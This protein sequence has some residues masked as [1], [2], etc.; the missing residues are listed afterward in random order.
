ML[1]APTEVV[2]PAE[3]AAVDARGNS[4]T[5]ALTAAHDAYCWGSNMFGQLGVSGNYGYWS[6]NASPAAV[7]GGYKFRKVS[8]GG[9]HTCGVGDDGSLWC[10]GSNG[11][12]EL[13]IAA[14][15]GGCGGYSQCQPSPSRIR[16]AADS[17]FTD[18]AAGYDHTC[19]LDA[20][21]AAYCWG[22]NA[23]GALGTGDTLSGSTPR[24]V[25]GDLV[26]V[27][28]TAGAQYTCGLTA[29]GDAYCWGTSY[30]GQLGSGTA[31]GSCGSAYYATP[32]E[33]APVMVS[34]GLRFSSLSA[35]TSMTCGM[36][37]DGAWC[38]GSYWGPNGSQSDVPVR[39]PGQR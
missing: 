15:D 8:P 18:V 30:N 1:S 34:G 14:V 13:G 28:L 35:G 27:A 6:A 20:A 22:G 33:T 29:S 38:W 2:L 39:V 4:H 12:G 5:C 17:V 32:C 7:A 3:P 16:V 11:S 36:A 10:W 23:A 31:S 19:A 21:G 26:F 37:S 24:K 25:A 9:N